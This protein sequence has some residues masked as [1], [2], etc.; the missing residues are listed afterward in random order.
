[1]MEDILF[2]WSQ[3]Y[4]VDITLIDE[5]HKQLIDIINQLYRALKYGKAKNE[6]D[7]IIAELVRYTIYHFETEEMYFSQF[8]YPYSIEHATEHTKFRTKIEEF[9]SKIEER[10]VMLSYE[11][12]TFLKNWLANHILISDK[13]FS[14]YIKDN[15][16][17]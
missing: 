3:K 1:M 15:H 17:M 13:K 4:S 11:V 12:M 6:I 7:V 9:K 16:L 14:L 2:E 5:Q 8:E 10:T